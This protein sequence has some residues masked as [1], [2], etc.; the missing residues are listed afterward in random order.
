MKMT[1]EQFE[2]IKRQLKRVMAVK[3]G[4]YAKKFAGIDIDAMKAATAVDK[5]RI[6]GRVNVVIVPEIGRSEVYPAGADFFEEVG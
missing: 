2:M 4:M 6:G 3:D 5:K 1:D